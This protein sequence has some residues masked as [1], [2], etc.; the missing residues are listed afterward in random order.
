MDQ[1]KQQQQMAKM[2]ELQ[3]QQHRLA[4]QQA[5]QQAAKQQQFEELVSKY[6]T[7]AQPEYLR[8]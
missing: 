7:P 4:L 6:R 5:Q 2:Q 3:M 1:W 8:C